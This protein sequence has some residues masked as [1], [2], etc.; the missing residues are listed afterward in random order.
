MDI[1]E[2]Y[3]SDP[4]RRASDELT[5]G[6]NWT[7][8]DDAD[9]LWDLFW[10][11]DTGELYLMSKPKPKW[12][13]PFTG[14]RHPGHH[15]SKNGLPPPGP[16]ETSGGRLPEDEELVVE[17]LAHVA[18]EEEVGRTL[19]GWEEAVTERDGLAWVRERVAGLS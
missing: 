8:A 9:H 12:L 13:P 2:F 15:R 3:D 10:V 17:I 5:F 1:D 18:S 11:R 14:E 4:R 7:S 16:E 6:L 19:S